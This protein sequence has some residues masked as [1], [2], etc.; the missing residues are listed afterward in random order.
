MASFLEKIL[1]HTRETVARAKVECP[2]AG[3]VAR[4]QARC[5][6]RSL[7]EALAPTD[8]P[9]IIA[10]VKRAS[11]S[12]GDIRPDLDPA[13]LAAAYEAG[14]AAAISVLTE[15]AFFKGSLTDL[16]AARR[17]VTLPVLR[18]DFIIDPYQVVE[19]AAAGADAVLI[20]VRI[21]DDVQLAELLDAVRQVGLEALV[22]VHSVDDLARASAVGARVIGINNRDLETFETRL[23][24]SIQIAARFGEDQLAVAASG[25]FGRDDIE[26]NLAVGIS[27]FLVGESLVRAADP[28]ALLRTLRG[29]GA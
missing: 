7:A 21:L 8:E 28:A 1:V 19:A 11:P 13:R 3:L 10:E 9:R 18:K 17:A 29:A 22:E 24:V 23:E 20:I 27:R 5:D 16:Q 14:G 15:T 26:H 4:A 6:V 25:I 12:R 2:E